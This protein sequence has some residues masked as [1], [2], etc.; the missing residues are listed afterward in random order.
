MVSYTLQSLALL[1]LVE[2]RNG[3]AAHLFAAA[4]ALRQAIGVR[5]PPED[6][7]EHDASVAAT[8]AHLG[9]AAFAGAWEEG[10]SNAAGAG[11]RARAGK[12]PTSSAHGLGG[13]GHARPTEL[14]P[15]AKLGQ[16]DPAGTGVAILV[17][18]GLTSRQIAAELVIAE[19]T[20]RIQVERILKKLGV[21]SRAEVAARAVERGLL[22]LSAD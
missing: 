18:R 14:G 22:R 8:R 4:E 5:L 17:A 7:A 3:R 6:R 1:D 11:D 16:P 21:H 15:S 19:G 12:R 9:E 10:R 13:R 2:G 20:V